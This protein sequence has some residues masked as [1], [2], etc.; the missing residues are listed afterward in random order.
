MCCDKREYS[1]HASVVTALWKEI[2][3]D[4]VVHLVGRKAMNQAKKKV[5]IK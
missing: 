5:G 4:R 1:Q 3:V 2:S